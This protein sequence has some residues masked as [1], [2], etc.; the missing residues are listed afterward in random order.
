MLIIETDS[1]YLSKGWTLFRAPSLPITYRVRLGKRFDPPQNAADFVEELDREFTRELAGAP[2]ET[3]LG[4]T[5]EPP[6]NRL[7]Q[8]E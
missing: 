1:S 4:Q 5:S 7:V 2:Q 6:E 8:T 3:W